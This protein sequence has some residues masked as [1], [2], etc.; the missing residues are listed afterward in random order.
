MIDG[1]Y[2]IHQHSPSEF[3]EGLSQLSKRKAIGSGSDYRQVDRGP[4]GF[5][6]HDDTK[7]P[8][9]DTIEGSPEISAGSPV[10]RG[11]DCGYRSG[12]VGVNA[13]AHRATR[14]MPSVRE[15]WRPKTKTTSRHIADRVEHAAPYPEL[16]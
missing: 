15:S 12:R 16:L 14:Q 2:R 8:R 6:H 11:G 4:A 7:T 5:I 3:D 1:I 10:E 9:P 13:L